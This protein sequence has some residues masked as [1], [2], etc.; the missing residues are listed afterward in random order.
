[1]LGLKHPHDDGGTGRPTFSQVGQGGINIDLF[2]VMSYT[3]FASWN[4]ISWDPATPMFMDVLALQALYGKNLSTN[5]GNSSFKLV[6]D[7]TYATIWDASGIDTIDGSNFNEGLSFLLPINAPSTIVDTQVGMVIP[8]SQATTFSP[9]YIRWLAGDFENVIGTR[10]GDDIQ[11]NRFNNMLTPGPGHDIVDGYSGIDTSIYSG[12]YGDYSLLKSGTK[13][14]V[15]DKVANR[16]GADLLTNIERLQFTDKSVALDLSPTQAAGQAALLTGAVLP[17][18]LALD[19]SKQPL[20]GSVISLFDQGFTL[21]QLSGAVLRLP[22]WDVLTQKAN[23]T[24]AD[25]AT[26]LV[27]NVYEGKQTTAITN[28]AINAMNA[29][30]STTQGSYLA[31]LALSIASQNHIDLVG[32]QTSGLVYLA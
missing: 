9:N 15:S 7:G 31:S 3:D 2:T 1:M 21:Q 11:G 10:F 30:T 6:A 8:V 22:I 32:I 17:G 27:N 4:L 24:T 23:P 14:I 26:Y 16:D 13:F 18:R 5:A 29:E 19:V 28:V 12:S 25:I 20:L